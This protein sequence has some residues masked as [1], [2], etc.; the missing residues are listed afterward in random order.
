MDVCSIYTD[1]NNCVMPP[2]VQ[3]TLKSTFAH[4]YTRINHTLETQRTLSFFYVDINHQLF[5]QTSKPIQELTDIAHNNKSFFMDLKAF[6]NSLNSLN[7]KI[8]V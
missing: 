8:S 1:K 3:K 2:A 6:E 5:G 4:K 7:P